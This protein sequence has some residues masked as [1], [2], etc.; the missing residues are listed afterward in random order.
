MTFYWLSFAD[1]SRP[2]GGQFLGVLIGEADDV[3]EVIKKAWRLGMNPG[4]EIQFHI[5]AQDLKV[6]EPLL[7]RL[8]TKQEAKHADQ[9]ILA[10]NSH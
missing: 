9:A 1:A 2:K 3:T 5:L 6:P 7:W 8:M 10:A 4:G